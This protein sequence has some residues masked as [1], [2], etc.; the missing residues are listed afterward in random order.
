MTH[1]KERL[2]RQT[3]DGINI[4]DLTSKN[5]LFELAFEPKDLLGLEGAKL[6]ADLKERARDAEYT[7][8]YYRD[9]VRPGII[10]FCILNKPDEMPT[11]G[12]LDR[13]R[14][15][16]EKV[17]PGFLAS[18]Q[19]APEDDHVLAQ[20]PSLALDNP[21][22]ATGFELITALEY[23]VFLYPEMVRAWAALCFAY[24][25]ILGMKDAA[26]RVREDCT[27]ACHHSQI[28]VHLSLG[29]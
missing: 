2:V 9:P 14:K 24:G 4:L 25:E 8:L 18:L 19:L 15:I 28:V 21:T 22:K 16:A 5:T 3:S 20:I 1:P 7:H 10:W 17:F 27:I 6:I 26:A 12:R 23:I 29:H 11:R 13:C